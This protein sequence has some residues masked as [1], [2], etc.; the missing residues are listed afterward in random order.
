MLP[1]PFP[2]AAPFIPTH[3]N[4]PWSSRLAFQLPLLSIGILIFPPRRFIHA[5]LTPL[6][7]MILAVSSLSEHE[8]RQHPQTISNIVAKKQIVLFALIIYLFYIS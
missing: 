3:F 2:S 8:L 6:L 5:S 1:E 4:L 7:T